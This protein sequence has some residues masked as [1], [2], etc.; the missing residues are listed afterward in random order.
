MS[1]ILAGASGRVY[2]RDK[3]LRAHPKRP[4]LNIYRAHCENQPV[5][6]KPVS[7]SIFVRA[8]LN[9]KRGCPDTNQLRTHVDANEDELREIKRAAALS[10]LD[11]ALCTPGLQRAKGK[12][13]SN[14]S[15]EILARLITFFGPVPPG[16]VA[17]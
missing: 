17:H 6:L 13:E 16:L 7:K 5:V 8:I 10:V 1:S 4:E 2:V 15:W 3:V 11:C 12:R 14:L 9:L